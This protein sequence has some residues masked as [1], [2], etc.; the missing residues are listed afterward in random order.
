MCACASECVRFG[1]GPKFWNSTNASKLWWATFYFVAAVASAGACYVLGERSA[2]RKSLAYSMNIEI[3]LYGRH[4]VGC[5]KAVS[6]RSH[7]VFD[8]ILFAGTYTHP[9]TRTLTSLPRTHSQ[10]HTFERTNGRSALNPKLYQMWAKQPIHFKATSTS[11]GVC[12][13][14]C[15]CIAVAEVR[16]AMM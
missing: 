16:R 8:C 14:V 9:H 6:A 12:V 1:I 4:C 5:S 7:S 3:S 2:R 13:C 10:Q 15:A 11:V